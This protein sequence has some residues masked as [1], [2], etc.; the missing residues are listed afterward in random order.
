MLLL[1][2]VDS[3]SLSDTQLL[4]LFDV[5]LSCFCIRANSKAYEFEDKPREASLQL[6]FQFSE[7]RSPKYLPNLVQPSEES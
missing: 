3:L 4:A 5:L 7:K 2:G 1:G 6:K